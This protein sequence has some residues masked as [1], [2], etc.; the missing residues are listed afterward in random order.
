[1]KTINE[2]D[3]QNIIEKKKKKTTVDETLETSDVIDSNI[4]DLRKIDNVLIESI[5]KK[6][7]K[8]C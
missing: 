1:M 7:K 4:Q 8:L 2:K 5:F 3:L 6:A